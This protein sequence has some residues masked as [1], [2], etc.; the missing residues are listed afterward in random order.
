M[1]ENGG[2]NE[3]LGGEGAD[4]A[5]ALSYLAEWINIQGDEGEVKDM[6]DRASKQIPDHVVPGGTREK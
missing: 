2:M 3:E 6:Q 5:A 4:E 1:A